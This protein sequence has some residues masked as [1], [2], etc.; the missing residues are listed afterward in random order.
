M[1]LLSLTAQKTD[2]QAEERLYPITNTPATS[3]EVMVEGLFPEMS[4]G[5][6]HVYPMN[7]DQKNEDYFFAGQ[8]IEPSLFYVFDGEW[9]LDQE[10]G[11]EVY[12]VYQIQWGSETAYIVRTLSPQG[13]QTLELMSFRDGYLQPVYQLARYKCVANTCVQK[14]SWIQDFD[15]DT[16]N[17]I[18]TKTRLVDE[19]SN[20]ILGENVKT[21]RYILDEGL[22]P[23]TRLRKEIDLQ[24]YL[25]EA[26]N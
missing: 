24:D 6:L 13:S 16:Y 3:T 9:Y 15:L 4:T 18:L 20:S 17:D 2:E 19:T 12:A 1:A 14:E 5:N 25:L 11:F 21:M 7:P 10:A 8:E 23:S 22:V 26:L